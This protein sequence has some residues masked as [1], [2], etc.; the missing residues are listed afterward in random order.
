M[1]SVSVTN[2]TLTMTI[3]IDGIETVIRK[4]NCKVQAF[5]TMVRI[6]DYKGSIYEFLY[7]DCTAPSQ[8]NAN[9][10][11]DAIEAFLNTGG[12]G[13]GGGL[14]SVDSTTLLVTINSGVATVNGIS[15]IFAPTISNIINPATVEEIS[16]FYSRSGNVVSGVFKCNVQL[17]AGDN[18]TSFEFTLPVSTSFANR[19]Q[20]KCTC[21]VVSNLVNL[22]GD[23]VLSNSKGII[24]ITAANNGDL[25]QEL[26]IAYQYLIV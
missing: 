6:T 2:Q 22:V 13:G 17:D 19:N 18:S 20:L 3:D 15:G 26:S 4:D 21:N 16:G 11:R 9:A 7:S 8:P 1:A 12:G 23:G 5:G 24:S 10:L 14:S 25:I